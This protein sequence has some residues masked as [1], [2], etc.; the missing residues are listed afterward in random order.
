M[1]VHAE[2]LDTC[3]EIKFQKAISDPLK[4]G[5]YK[6]MCKQQNL[7]PP[8]WDQPSKHLKRWVHRSE[9]H[10][11]YKHISQRGGKDEYKKKNRNKHHQKNEYARKSHRK[12]SIKHAYFK[13]SKLGSDV[14]CYDC[15]GNHYANDCPKRKQSAK[16]DKEADKK[17]KAFMRNKAGKIN[18]HDLSSDESSDSS[19]VFYR[20]K[21]LR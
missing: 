16:D 20:N 17:T 2:I 4:A 11:R 19:L 18:V 8:D 5:S 7:Q 1:A 6:D 9:K 3:K 12:H 10:S 21:S 14:K 15:G 13:N